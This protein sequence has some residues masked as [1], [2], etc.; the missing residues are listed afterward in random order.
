MPPHYG[1]V[2]WVEGVEGVEKVERVDWVE[3]V[4]SYLVTVTSKMTPPH[5]REA[6]TTSTRSPLTACIG[7]YV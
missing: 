2:G 3:W 1:K 6:S 5:A 7:V 4:D